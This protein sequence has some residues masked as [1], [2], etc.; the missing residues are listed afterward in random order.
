[1]CAPMYRN[2]TTYR[3]MIVEHWKAGMRT[4]AVRI[5][6]DGIDYGYL[7][8]QTPRKGEKWVDVTQR[9]VANAMFPVVMG[10]EFY[11][12]HVNRRHVIACGMKKIDRALDEITKLPVFTER[13]SVSVA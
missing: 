13:V 11:D 8:V 4:Q 12:D 7:D 1:M 9:Y 2:Q 3:R 10:K 6:V 5:L